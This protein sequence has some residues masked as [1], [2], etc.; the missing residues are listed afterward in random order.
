MAESL[1]SLEPSWGSLIE[2]DRCC[3]LVEMVI[4]DS[5]QAKHLVRTAV[6]RKFITIQGCLD[7]Q[8]IAHSILG[9]KVFST[10]NGFRILLDDDSSC[11]PHFHLE[12]NSLFG[13]VETCSGAGFMK[14]GIDKG[15][16][17]VFATNDLRKTMTEFQ[18]RQG[19]TTT[20]TGDI[21]KDET[22]K[23]LFELHA[24][25]CLLA[26]G[27]SCQ[28]WSDLGDKKGMMDCRAES[29]TSILRAAFFLRS[30]SIML[31]CVQNA[32]QDKQVREILNTFCRITGFRQ[33]HI[34]LSLAAFWPSRRARWFR[35][36]ASS[37]PIGSPKDF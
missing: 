9:A 34:D 13:A 37:K 28:P 1:L 24:K 15:G 8:A 35:F 29:L 30:H 12:G 10:H 20:V 14:D 31:E 27:F 16:F 21:G 7:K 5:H 6:H 3:L 19:F 36:A 32:G 33:S 22:I 26:G 23:G 2:G 4:F 11:L 17:S 18:N 25:P